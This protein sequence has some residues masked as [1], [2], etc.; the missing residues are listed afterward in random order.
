MD[1]LI[2]IFF[3]LKDVYVSGLSEIPE[4]EVPRQSIRNPDGM[5][6][7]HSVAMGFSASNRLSNALDINSKF[8]VMRFKNT[9]K[10]WLCACRERRA[11]DA[12]I[13]FLVPLKL[14]DIG[15]QWIFPKEENYPSRNSMIEFLNK[16]EEYM[17]QAEDNKAYNQTTLERLNQ[18]LSF[19]KRTIDQNLLDLA[20]WY[21]YLFWADPIYKESTDPYAPDFIS[22][23]FANFDQVL[24]KNDNEVKKKKDANEI[25]GKHVEATEDVVQELNKR[26]LSMKERLPEYVIATYNNE[27]KKLKYTNPM[28]P[29]YANQVEFLETVLDL[30]WGNYTQ[31]GITVD[32]VLNKMNATHYGLKDTKR[33][34]AEHIALQHWSGSSYGEVLCLIGPPGVGKSSLANVVADTLERRYIK[35]ALGGMGDESEFRGHRRTYVSSEPGRLVKELIRVKSFDPVIV[36]DEIDKL[37][38]YRGSPADALLEILDPEQNDH[39]VDRYLS[40][41]IDISRCMFI[42]TANYETDIPA[43]LLDR[44]SVIRIDGYSFEE[45]MTI[46]K[47]YIIPKFQKDWKLECV[48]I[49]DSILEKIATKQKRGVR[50]MERAVKGI[51]KKSSFVLQAEK[52]DKLLVTANNCEALIGFNP[53]VHGK[54][55]GRQETGYK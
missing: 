26:F 11:K 38:T 27:A 53:N 42:C 44:M 48:E 2:N 16:M 55:L 20:F 32:Q 35:I 37:Q 10:G 36:L 54:P 31:N 52:K 46:A 5:L 50:D 9:D 6:P 4:I 45:Q 17:K 40:F 23:A 12:V 21:G 34:I 41:P 24:N 18:V 51:L 1:T 14:N 15:N 7:L 33:A 19:V 47:N 25:V 43:P 29:D 49:E 39:F 8:F 28:A 13:I 3:D 30:P 22:E